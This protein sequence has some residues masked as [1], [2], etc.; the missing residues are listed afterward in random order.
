[1]KIISK[2]IDFYDYL[3]HVYGTDPLITFKRKEIFDPTLKYPHN[4]YFNLKEHIDA[5]PFVEFDLYLKESYI[6]KYGTTKA[7]KNH[8]NRHLME[9]GIY[10]LVL[11]GVPVPLLY[12]RKTYAKDEEVTRVISI[13]EFKELIDFE[14]G[15]QWKYER[16]S[17]FITELEKGFNKKWIPFHQH[18]D[19]PYFIVSDLSINRNENN[20]VLRVKNEIPLLKNIEGFTST[21]PAEE[22]FQSISMF[23]SSHL[24][25]NKNEPP[26]ELED[27]EKI[28]KAGFDTKIS[29]RHRGKN[30]L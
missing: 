4:K 7:D 21:F 18:M 23:I 6:K 28:V 8:L 10:I 24:N 14:N 30:K 1:M 5:N 16:R 27:K 15:D 20:F 29:F 11:C 19:S 13:E 9:V 25:G 3:S 2:Q 12:V 17:R 26:I 22:V